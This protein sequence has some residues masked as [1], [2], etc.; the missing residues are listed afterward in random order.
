MFLKFLLFI[1]LLN[2]YFIIHL[3]TGELTLHTYFEL[4]KN[5]E[6]SRAEMNEVIAERHFLEK[7]IMRK[8][9]D[10]E[11]LDDFARE[12][13]GLSQADEFILTDQ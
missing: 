2:A 1:V 4:K 9:I 12:K 6:K 5:I 3:F 10:L 8:D 7:I 13:L 11:F